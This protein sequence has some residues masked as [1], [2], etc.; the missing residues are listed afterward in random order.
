MDSPSCT[1]LS[2]YFQ[3]YKGLTKYINITLAIPINPLNL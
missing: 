1:S 3:L 2:I